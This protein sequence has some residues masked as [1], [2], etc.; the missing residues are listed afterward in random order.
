MSNTTKGK[1]SRKT[2]GGTMTSRKSPRGKTSKGGGK[3]K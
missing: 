2:G 3:K 1:T